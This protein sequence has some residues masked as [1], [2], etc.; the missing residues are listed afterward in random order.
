MPDTIVPI[1]RRPVRRSSTTTDPK[2]SDVNNV[3]RKLSIGGESNSEQSSP[4]RL[5]RT[6]TPK[7]STTPERRRSLL[8]PRDDPTPVE[9][10]E[11][12]QRSAISPPRAGNCFP[13]SK[14]DNLPSLPVA[15]NRPIKTSKDLELER[16]VLQWIVSVVKEKPT[17]D[18]DRFIQ[19]GTILSKLMISIVFNSV[20][21][22]QIYTNWGISPV[23]DRV[24]SVIHE[25][26]RYGVTDL[27][28]PK[29]LMELRNIPLVTKSLAQLC[30]L[31]AADSTNLLPN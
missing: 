12:Q 11:P 8:S 10:P 23:L 19:D 25:M 7:E 1:V 28:E 26:R 9:T 31:A 22:E 18:Y 14:R 6:W 27:F 13:V 29:D 30:K 4:A 2:I 5:R 24:K 21:I 20:P 3:V 16:K 15:R 17:T